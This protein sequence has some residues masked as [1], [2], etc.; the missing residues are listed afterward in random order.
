MPEDCIE[1]NC[2]DCSS[3]AL[4]GGKKLDCNYM[5]RLGISQPTVKN[6]IESSPKQVSESVKVNPSQSLLD[7]AVDEREAIENQIKEL[8]EK[9][10]V[11]EEQKKLDDQR[12]EINEL[13]K[14]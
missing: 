8:E 10:R 2:L 1:K 9:R 6:F 5:N 11:L 4:V 13:I 7:V 12:K 14:Q 3:H